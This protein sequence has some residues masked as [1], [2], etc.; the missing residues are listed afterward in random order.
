MK[1]KAILGILESPI[2]GPAEKIIF[3]RMKLAAID[4]KAKI[5]I[6]ELARSANMSEPATH[7]AIKRLIG[8]SLLAMEK[9][10]EEIGKPCIYTLID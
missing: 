6:S 4:G 2:M 8:K 3:L 1:E 10:V 7:R 5:T 9:A